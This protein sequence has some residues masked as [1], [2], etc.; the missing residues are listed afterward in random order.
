M[1][2]LLNVVSTA[3]TTWDIGAIIND[4]KTTTD[5]VVSEIK[6]EDCRTHRFLDGNQYCEKSLQ[7]K[8]NEYIQTL[9]EE[10]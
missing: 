3:K 2:P 7:H 5:H 6:Q 8:L 9:E 10:Y 1:P 4:E